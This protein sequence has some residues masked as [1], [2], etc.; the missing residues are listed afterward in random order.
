MIVLGILAILAAIVAMCW[1]LFNLAVFALP[2][3]I[4]LQ[5]GIWAYGTGGGWFGAVFAGLVAAA[6]TLAVGQ[7]LFMLVRP[8]WARLLVALVFVAPA[9]LAGFHAS[10][11][12][13]RA[14][15]PSETWQLIFA[16]IG[17]IAVGITAFIRV[18]GLAAPGPSEG[19]L[20][21]A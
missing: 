17:G 6:L 8:I 10:L 21:R 15:M 11:G 3:L 4:G 14:V 13:A 16:V 2:F 20:A 7:G 9:A 19:N 18:A 5:S 1:L 12:V